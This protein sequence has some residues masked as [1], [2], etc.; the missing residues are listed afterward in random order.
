MKGF[1]H[2][3]N[4]LR[5]VF[6]DVDASG[7]DFAG[8]VENDELGVFGVAGEDDAVGDLTEHGFVE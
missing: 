1:E 3:E 7:E 5:G 6:A 2:L 4:A 8:G